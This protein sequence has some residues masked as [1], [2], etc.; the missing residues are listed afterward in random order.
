MVDSLPGSANSIY[1]V[2]IVCAGESGIEYA[3]DPVQNALAYAWYLPPG[4]SI[5][6]G[7]YTN[8]IFV[9][10]DPEASSGEIIAVG[11]NLCGDGLP[12]PEFFLLVNPIPSTPSVFENEDTLYSSESIGNQWYYEGS[13]LANDTSQIHV[14]DPAFPGCYWT[15]VTLNGCV[16]DTSN[17]YCYTPV[18]INEYENRRCW[19]F[20]NPSSTHI[21]IETTPH[22]ELTIFSND[23]KE[24]I[25]QKATG[26]Q[27]RI[28]ISAIPSGIY[29]VKIVGEKGVQVGRFV[30]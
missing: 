19:I 17:H 27:T 3:I 2:S 15:Q 8:H 14:L 4:A 9:N 13:V 10:F 21:T 7:Q 25:R 1:G 22:S 20:P 23:G 30:K 16:S 18:G 6:S 26:S 29:L 5:F 12:S 24:L 28:D 11:N